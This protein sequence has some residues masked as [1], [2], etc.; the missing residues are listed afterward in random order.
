MAKKLGVTIVPYDKYL[1][2]KSRAQGY[3]WLKMIQLLPEG[4]R[5]RCFALASQSKSQIGQDLFVLATLGF[6][7]EGY[8]VE[9]GATDGV[10][11]S[12]SFLL[13]QEFGWTGILAE[14]ARNWHAALTANRADAIIDH[15]CVWKESGAQLDFTEAREGERSGATALMPLSWRLG[16]STYP[17]QTISLS[18]LLEVHGA[19]TVIDYLSIDT[20]GS[21]HDILSVFDFS[22]FRFRVI[23]VEHNYGPQRELIYKLLT[24][25]GYRRVHEEVSRWD[26]WYVSN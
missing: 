21:E 15:R 1:S 13:A 14:P 17:V 18:E 6:P 10:S 25:K 22:R 16:G 11:L 7:K 26:D 23:T 24:S 20:E 4:T 3:F 2:L 9:F 12:N 19:P 8:F 5:E